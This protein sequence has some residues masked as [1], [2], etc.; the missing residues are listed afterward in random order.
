MTHTKIRILLANDN[1]EKLTD[2]R[3]ALGGM[4]EKHRFVISTAH[5]WTGV[6]KL[7]NHQPYHLMVSDLVMPLGDGID[8]PNEFNIQRDSLPFGVAFIQKNAKNT[9][10]V[11]AKSDGAIG[12]AFSTQPNITQLMRCG[13]DNLRDWVRSKLQEIDTSAA[14]ERFEHT[15]A[16]YNGMMQRRFTEDHHTM[17]QKEITKREQN[18][19]L[20]V[21]CKDYADMGTVGGYT[22]DDRYF[23]DKVK[24]KSK[25]QEIGR[26]NWE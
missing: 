10:F 26:G 4:K 14:D 21:E 13:L 18:G 6:K 22:H 12:D 7:L 8:Q 2:W 23:T 19:S 15:N 5:D 9:R 17:V 1:R 25:S 11:A 16:A 24:S 20:P 3:A